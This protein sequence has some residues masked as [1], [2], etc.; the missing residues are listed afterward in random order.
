MGIT[1][2]LVST[3]KRFV[4]YIEGPAL[5]VDHLLASI[6][7]DTRHSAVIILQ[8]VDLSQRFFDRWNLAYAGPDAFIDEELVRVI[9]TEPTAAKEVTALHLRR[10]L[11]AM[12]EHAR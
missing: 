9:Q 2:A 10:R 6:K 12:A 11:A 4:Q 8:D 1:G 5:H 3:E 7:A